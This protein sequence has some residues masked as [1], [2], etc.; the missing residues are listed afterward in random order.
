MSVLPSCLYCVLAW[1]HR[2]QKS[3][4]VSLEMEVLLGLSH[5]V[6]GIESGSQKEQPVFL[7]TE[8]SLHPRDN[9]FE[10]PCI[11]TYDMSSETQD[12]LE[13]V[14]CLFQSFPVFSKSN[15][16]LSLSAKLLYH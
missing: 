7:T 12:V 2:A 4:L 6:L 16:A 3:E 10:N 1:D 15:K 8:P 11:T 14:P 13:N 9:P 5:T